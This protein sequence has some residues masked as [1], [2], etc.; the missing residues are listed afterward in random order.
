M[1]A[2]F[3]E[4][5]PRVTDGDPAQLLGALEV[6]SR[7]AFAGEIERNALE[8][9]WLERWLRRLPAYL[10]WQRDREA[11]GWHFSQAETRCEMSFEL[12]DGAPLRLE[13]RIDRIDA[14]DDGSLAVLDYKTQ[15]ATT[16]AARLKPAGE[17][18]QLAVYTILQGDAVAQAAYVA[19]DDDVKAR[20]IDE[21]QVAAAEQYQRLIDAFS[22]MR[23]GLPLPAHGA[24]GVCHHCAA[25]GLCR[26]DWF[27]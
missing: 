13:G 26:R 1:L 19:L 17:D 16:L 25:R 5:Y 10:D 20:Q 21:P 22:G 7:S 27:E 8:L 11:A 4:R 15:S 3:H 23:A 6:E 9:G 2:K 24:V 12:A 18:V 14:R